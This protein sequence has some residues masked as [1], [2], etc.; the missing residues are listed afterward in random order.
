MLSETHPYVF[1]RFPLIVTTGRGWRTN[2]LMTF[3]VREHST[4]L[5]AK[6]ATPAE[7]V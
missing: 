1:F 2:L 4:A 5:A 7:R 3:T 6:Y